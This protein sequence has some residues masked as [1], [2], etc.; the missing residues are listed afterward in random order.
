MSEPIRILLH[1]LED[2]QPGARVQTFGDQQGP[3]PSEKAKCR[4]CNGKGVVSRFKW[5]C[6]TCGGTLDPRKNGRGWVYVDQ[7]TEQEVGTSETGTVQ[8]EI[9]VVCDSC[10]GDGVYGNGRRC[11]YCDGSGRTLCSPTLKDPTEAQ[12]AAREA[13]EAH[14]VALNA[15]RAVGSPHLRRSGSF[16]ALEQAV[17]ELEPWERRILEDETDDGYRLI[18]TRHLHLKVV[19]KDGRVKVPRDCKLWYQERKASSNGTGRWANGYAKGRRNE[20]IR[21][22]SKEG[23]RGSQI[24]RRLG[25]SEATV[26]RVLR[27]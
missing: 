12:Q 24:A 5:P 20:E 26:S 7:Y 3:A 13:V 22:L 27:G 18:L 6:Q 23:L 15:L 1:F 21:S 16:A 9:F 8:R 11:R 14:S 2:A 25:V 10:A 19:E 17:Q 4:V